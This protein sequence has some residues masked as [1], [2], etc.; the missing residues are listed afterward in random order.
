MAE[1]DTHLFATSS[2]TQQTHQQ[3]Q[4]LVLMNNVIDSTSNHTTPNS[5]LNHFVSPTINNFGDDACTSFDSNSFLCFDTENSFTSSS[6]D[7]HSLNGKYYYL[8]YI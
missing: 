1:K 5:Q 6:Y 3:Q 7:F 4:Q 8:N 2:S